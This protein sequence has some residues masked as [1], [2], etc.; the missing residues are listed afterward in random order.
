MYTH[1]NY[2]YKCSCLLRQKQQGAYTTTALAIHDRAWLLVG[3]W[4]APLVRPGRLFRSLE[5]HFQPLVAHLVRVHRLYGRL[6]AVRVVVRHEPYIRRRQQKIKTVSILSGA[7]ILILNHIG[8]ILDN[9]C[10]NH[11]VGGDFSGYMTIISY[12]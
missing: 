10:T 5:L 3:R 8:Y 7:L 11:H 1:N 4:L 2:Y 9:C 12:L 6:R